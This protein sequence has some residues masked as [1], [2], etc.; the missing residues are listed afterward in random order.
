MIKR[1]IIRII[2][3]IAVGLTLLF[4]FSFVTGANSVLNPAPPN[5]PE[6]PTATTQSPSEAN[7][8]L[9]IVGLGDSLTRGIGDDSGDGYFGKT[10]KLLEKELD[11]TLVSTNLAVSGAKTSDLLPLLEQNGVIYTISQADIIVLTIGANDLSPGASNINSESLKTLNP[12]VTGFAAASQQIITKIRAI[13]PTATI[14]WLSLYN[15]FEDVEGMQD[16]GKL[17][18]GWN[19]TLEQIALQYPKVKIVPTFDLFHEQNKTFLS[20]DHYHPS[21]LG[22]EAMAERLTEVVLSDIEAGEA[23][24]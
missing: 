18:L 16:A 14:Y 24:E 12:D 10:K 8:N 3:I 15:P 21:K 4:V 7:K 11:T 9:T 2:I 19:S 13:N 6:Q 1:M 20:G 22:Y 5:Q 17:V 23:D